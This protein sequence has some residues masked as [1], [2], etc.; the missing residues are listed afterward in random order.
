MKKNA[1]LIIDA[2]KMRPGVER[3][4]AL[5][6]AFYYY[7]FGEPLNEEGKKMERTFV[8]CQCDYEYETED[9]DGTCPRCKEQDQIRDAVVD[10][11]L[12]LHPRHVNTDDIG[13]ALDEALWKFQRRVKG[14]TR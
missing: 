13:E 2:M 12:D 6:N 5:M 4:S 8:C 10:V 3:D 11:L 1:T 14:E 9:G 7:L